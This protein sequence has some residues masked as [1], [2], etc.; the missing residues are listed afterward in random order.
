MPTNI[1][2][3]C[4]KTF[5]QNFHDTAALNLVRWTILVDTVNLSEEAKK[6]T[7][8]DIQILTKIEDILQESAESRLFT[9]ILFS[10]LISKK[11]INFKP[12]IFYIKKSY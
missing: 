6:V 5:F 4:I 9:S 8:L 2:S 3:Y 11:I 10:H 12:N 1:F 7:K